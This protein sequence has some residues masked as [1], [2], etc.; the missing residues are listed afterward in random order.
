MQMAVAQLSREMKG[1]GP[2][3]FPDREDSTA[4]WPDALNVNPSGEP[5]A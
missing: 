5:T 4:V 1:L 2:Q 3:L